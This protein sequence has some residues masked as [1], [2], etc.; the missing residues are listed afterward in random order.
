M[1]V[2]PIN[3]QSR[4]TEIDAEALENL[5]RFFRIMAEWDEEDRLDTR[6]D[7]TTNPGRVSSPAGINLPGGVE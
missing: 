3:V 6:Q 7:D 2:P 4:C 1:G 5:R